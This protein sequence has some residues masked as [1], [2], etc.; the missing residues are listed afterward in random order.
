MV[1]YLKVG[2]WMS[3]D[4]LAQ[5]CDRQPV[6]LHSHASL[7]DSQFAVRELAG[8]IDITE[9]EWLSLHLDVPAQRIFNW[10]KRLGV[11]FA[12]I[13]QQR[14]LQLAQKNIADLQ[15]HLSIP[16]A[17]ENQAYHRASGHNYVT[18]PTFIKKMITDTNI[19]L[20]LDLGHARVSAA[21][22]NISIYD[23]LLSLPLVQV[24]EIHINGPRLY[25]G[26]L[27]DIH[28]PL[29]EID[30]E[31]LEFI[32]QYC[33]QVKVITLEFYGESEILLGQL[34]R[35]REISQHAKTVME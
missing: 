11:P 15:K 29:Q 33:P 10:H 7:I 16:V 24:N 25:R 32:L 19:K 1:D 18:E 6:L 30:Y 34:V 26:R 13:S 2:R 14:A 23:Y 8:L 27:R 22:R 31:I 4:W 28:A 5:C 21:M 9:T 17:L 20:L 3:N 35:L 12:L